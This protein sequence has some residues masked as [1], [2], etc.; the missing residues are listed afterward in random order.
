MSIF[1]KTETHENQKDVARKIN[2]WKS[3]F[4]KQNKIVTIN[5][6]STRNYNS[7]VLDHAVIITKN[8]DPGDC[9][10]LSVSVTCSCI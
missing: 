6:K 4:K 7:T 5:V 3:T 9:G 1:L 2:I 8:E 10:H